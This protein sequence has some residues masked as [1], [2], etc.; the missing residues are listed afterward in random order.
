MKIENNDFITI[1]GSAN[2]N[3]MM[4]STNY[5]SNPTVNVPGGSITHVE[6]PWTLNIISILFSVNVDLILSSKSNLS[7]S[8]PGFMIESHREVALIGLESIE[9]WFIRTKYIDFLT[10]HTQH[11][12]TSFP[13][14]NYS[15]SP[16]LSWNPSKHDLQIVLNLKLDLEGSRPRSRYPCAPTHHPGPF[17]HIEFRIFTPGSSPACLDHQKW[18]LSGKLK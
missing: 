3:V 16:L 14:I 8:W 7:Q 11:M 1:L 13:N 2:L 5:C 17:E 9:L 6:S 12:Y 15:F 10:R 18:W 4:F